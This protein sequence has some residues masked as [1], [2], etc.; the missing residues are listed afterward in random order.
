MRRRKGT[1]RVPRVLI[2]AMLFAL[3]G[4][5]PAA[6][7]VDL[8]T[9]SPAEL[10]T[11]PGVGPV[12]SRRIIEGRP[13]ESID[14]LTRVKGIGVK[15][16]GRL[17]DLITVEALFPTKGPPQEKGPAP[18]KADSQ[19]A[20]K[21]PVYRVDTYT[22]LTCFRCKN[23]FKVSSDLKTGWCPYCGSRLAVR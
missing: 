6:G 16:F 3:C 11:L 17:K 10:Q 7:L 22:Q 21:V 12:L 5:R 15:T 23:K 13:Y 4:I 20:S 1:M 8:N 14:E 19:E 2:S 9:A 18:G